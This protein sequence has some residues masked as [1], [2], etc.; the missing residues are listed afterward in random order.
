MENKLKKLFD[1]QRFEQNSE[2]SSLI[3]QTHARS[4]KALSD[5]DLDLV[6]AAG[7]IEV[8]NEKKNEE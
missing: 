5:D 2:L 4:S 3:A 7:D 1:F 6:N 8:M